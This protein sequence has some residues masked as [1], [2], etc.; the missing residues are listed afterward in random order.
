MPRIRK[1]KPKPDT[2]PV[3][4]AVRSMRAKLRL[5]QQELADLLHLA[6]MTVSRFERGVQVPRDAEVLRSLRD[7]AHSSAALAEEY[8]VFRR[9]STFRFFESKMEWMATQRVAGPARPYPLE[10]WELMQCARVAAASF[11]EVAKA[12]RK[13]AGEVLALVKQ[14]ERAADV[15]ESFDDKFYFSLEQKLDDLVQTV[16]F[17][18]AKKGTDR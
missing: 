12:M 14:V 18:R 3:C 9:E 16:S 15:P 1:P 4:A 11:P 2:H 5:S 10:Q 13:A 17:E 6:P 7:A 8:E